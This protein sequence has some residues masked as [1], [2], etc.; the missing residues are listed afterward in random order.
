MRKTERKLAAVGGGKW[1]SQVEKRMRS[2][3][4]SGRYWITLAKN[5]PNAA[6]LIA[7]QCTGYG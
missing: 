5:M 3:C 1:V 7:V 6:T 2:N 4:K